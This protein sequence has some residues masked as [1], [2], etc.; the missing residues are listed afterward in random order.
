MTKYPLVKRLCKRCNAETVHY[1]KTHVTSLTRHRYQCKLCVRNI[2]IA[3]RASL[4]GAV[5]HRLENYMR[6]R[7]SECA[8]SATILKLIGLDTWHAVADHIY[9]QLPP[10]ETTIKGYE[11]DH[12]I[13]TS[14]YNMNNAE[15]RARCFNWQNL[16]L[17][18]TAENRAKYAKLPFWPQLQSRKHLWPISWWGP[19]CE[20][21]CM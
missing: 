3:A 10:G 19:E 6:R 20:E 13:P 18:T 12:V 15:D 17:L 16:Q 1:Q 11:I 7:L 9:A 5:R 14:R 8:D 2:A 21:A 4:V